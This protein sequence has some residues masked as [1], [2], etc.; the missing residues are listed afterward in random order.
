V[1]TGEKMWA[2]VATQKADEASLVT[3]EAEA[4]LARFGERLVALLATLKEGEVSP[5]VMDTGSTPQESW[6][7]E[8]GTHGGLRCQ[9]GTGG[10]WRSVE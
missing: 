6:R 2:S 5:V 7:E 1:K 9:R 3:M 8:D 4:P 10:A